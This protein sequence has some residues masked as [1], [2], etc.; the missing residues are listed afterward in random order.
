MVNDSMGY[1]IE[2]IAIIFP[3]YTILRTIKQMHGGF[4]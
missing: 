2:Y 4:A 1:F 3:E